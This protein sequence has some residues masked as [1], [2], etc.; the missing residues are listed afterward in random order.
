ME[1]KRCEEATKDSLD[2]KS[3][4]N[5]VQS[6]E[7]VGSSHSLR[8]LAV[9]TPKKN[10]E[11]AL[12]LD[13]DV[14][15]KA[16]KSEDVAGNLPDKYKIL[17]EFFDRIG[18]SVR[19]LSLCK[20]MPTF[21]NICTQV[22]VFTKRKLSY[23]HLAQI[24]YILPEAVQVE[25]ILV[26][27]ERT[28][29]MK[30]DMKITLLLDVVEAHPDQ[31]PYVVL[32]QMFRQ[33]LLKFFSNHPEGCDIPEAALPIQMCESRSNFQHFLPEESRVES[34]ARANELE[35]S[36]SSSLLPSTFKRRFSEKIIVP[37]TEKTNLLESL[38][39][40]SPL[41]PENLINQDPEG[42]EQKE[43]SPRVIETAV[44]M[45]LMSSNEYES[46]PMKSVSGPN[47][48]MLVTPTQSAPQRRI[49]PDSD[50]KVISASNASSH[51]VA[52]KSLNFFSPLKG[53]E[54]AS[55]SILDESKQYSDSYLKPAAAK[56]ILMVDDVAGSPCP[57]IQEEE[58]NGGKLSRTASLPD[59]FNLIYQIFHSAKY[60]SITKQEL[61][62]KIISE[63]VLIEET[64][65]AEEQLDLLE[66]LVPEIQK[67]LVPSGDLLYSIKKGSDLDSIRARLVEAL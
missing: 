5:S 29:C 66:E 22:E 2:M 23:S 51:S 8:N 55:G 53:D 45:L 1:F 60:S 30:Q 38:H 61:V 56:R 34:R 36:S 17:A 28:L 13:T 62:Y 16:N 19:W 4:K 67:K 33:R 65:E 42:V 37:E 40:F 31:S 57:L 12:P 59:L 9:P 44:P 11:V 48:L 47:Q 35:P 58:M 32:C 46:S 39:P 26:H 27:D 18:S 63:D 49:A 52:K 24:K 50:E 20:K 25:K 15:G 21:Q 10:K 7:I 14:A 41:E 43:C 54:K 64:E 6:A 3:E